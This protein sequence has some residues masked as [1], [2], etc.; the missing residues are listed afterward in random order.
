MFFFHIVVFFLSLAAC[1]YY[2]DFFNTDRHQEVSRPFLALP[3]KSAR[4]T[5]MRG[6]CVVLATTLALG[7]ATTPLSRL[8]TPV[9][10]GTVTLSPALGSHMVLQRSEPARIWGSAGAGA[11]VTVALSGGCGSADR[12]QTRANASG[13]WQ[14]DLKAQSACTAPA[15]ISATADGASSSTRGRAQRS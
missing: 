8:A 5:G 1:T 13:E 12:C 15:S 2:E 3:K 4:I 6:L 10:P 9:A 11:V 7:A 14:C